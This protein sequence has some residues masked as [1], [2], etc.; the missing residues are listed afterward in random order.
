[1]VVRNSVISCQEEGN[2]LLTSQNFIKQEKSNLNN[3]SSSIRN[4]SLTSHSENNSNTEDRNSKPVDNILVGNS[5]MTCQEEGNSLLT[6]RLLNTSENNDNTKNIQDTKG[7]NTKITIVMDNSQLNN[8]NHS[9][10]QKHTRENDNSTQVTEE[11]N[12]DKVLLKQI[13]I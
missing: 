5:V 4:S 12:N 8:Q 3:T 11:T 9:E 1:M 6:S 7:G 2:S 10:S 13:P